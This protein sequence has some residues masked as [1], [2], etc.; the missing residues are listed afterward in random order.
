MGRERGPG[1]RVR[2]SGFRVRGSGFRVQGS[3]FRVRGSGVRGLRPCWFCTVLLVVLAGLLLGAACQPARGEESLV[4]RRQRVENLTLS[5]KERLLRLQERFASLDPAEQQRLRRLAE[6]LERDPNAARLRGIMRRYYEWLK[7]LTPPQR[8][9][10]SRLAPAERVER[11]RK[12]KQEQARRPPKRPAIKNALRVEQ[13]KK[14]LQEQGSRLGKRL[15]PEDVDGLFQWSE[16]M[17]DRYGSRFLESLPETRRREVQQELAVMANPGRRRQLLGWLWME[18]RGANPG[19]APPMDDRD[20]A[21]LRAKLSKPT[22]ERLESLPPAEQWRAVA[23]WIGL[24]QQDKPAVR[25][26]DELIPPK[27]E[28]ELALFFEHGLSE[29]EQD[30]L[31]SLPGEQML[32]ELLREYARKVAPGPARLAEQA[33]A[34]KRA[35]AGPASRPAKPAKSLPSDPAA[36]PKKPGRSD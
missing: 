3:G 15:S 22:R 18:W 20:L 34:A 1:F 17:A 27:M 29:E 19:K 16:Q 26:P 8:L 6:Q 35:G 5:E 31:L 7:T 2:G 36:S 32:R 30:R 21:E 11:I 9:E 4:E 33:P 12:L 10:L 25:R 14:L 13:M 24:F 23:E 28:E